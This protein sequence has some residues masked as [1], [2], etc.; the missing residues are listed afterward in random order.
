MILGSTALNSNKFQ[1]FKFGD[2]PV[3][4]ELWFYFTGIGRRPGKGQE[5]D[6]VEAMAFDPAEAQSKGLEGA[7]ASVKYYSFSMQ[8]QID[9]FVNGRLDKKTGQRGSPSMFVGK[10]YKIKYARPQG[11]EYTDKNGNT[12]KTESIGYDIEEILVEKGTA[13]AFQALLRSGSVNDAMEAYRQANA[14]MVQGTAPVSE[15]PAAPSNLP[16]L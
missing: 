13:E 11:T 8:A 4:T 2:H 14:G 10:F 15:T 3:G 16:K 6:V 1:A 7:L 9:S 5:F 12:K